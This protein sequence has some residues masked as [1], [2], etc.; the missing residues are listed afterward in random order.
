MQAQL[1]KLVIEFG[2]PSGATSRFSSVYTCFEAGTTDFKLCSCGW[3]QLCREVGHWLL[4]RRDEQSPASSHRKQTT[5][6]K[7]I[8]RRGTN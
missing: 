1:V 3:L 2:I 6:S 8:V 7:S 5:S 4:I